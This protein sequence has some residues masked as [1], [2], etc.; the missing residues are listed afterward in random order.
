MSMPERLAC[1][2]L[3]YSSVPTIEPNWV[4]SVRSVSRWSVA[5]AMPKS[6]TL[7]TGLP[8]IPVTRTFDGLISRWMIPFWCACWIAWQTG[9]NSSSRSRGE[10]RASSQYWVIGMP[11]ISSMTKNGRPLSVAPASSTRAILGCSIIASAC[12]SASKR[13]RTWAESMPGLITFR[14]TRRRTGWSCSAMNTAPIPPSPI[15]WSSRYG[16]ICDPGPSASGGRAAG[17]SGID[18]GASRVASSDD[19]GGSASVSEPEA[20]E[21]PAGPPL[22]SG[23][24]GPFA[25][26]RGCRRPGNHGAAV[27]RAPACARRVVRRRGP[28]KAGRHR[29]P[30]PDRPPGPRRTAAP[31]RRGR[32]P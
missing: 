6:I 4:N 15:C 24:L 14:A 12:R 8:S 28:A 31:P 21:P 11:L 10:S 18:H 7:G 17:W 22:R 25:G 2:G 27:A 16:P 9:T 26:R 1:S 19:G 30:D 29:T 3:M 13:A 32:S 23:G 5:L 20:F